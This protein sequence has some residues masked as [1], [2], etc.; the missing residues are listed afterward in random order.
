MVDLPQN[1]HNAFDS[2]DAISLQQ[3]FTQVFIFIHFS[4]S[5]S[6]TTAPAVNKVIQHPTWLIC[7]LNEIRLHLSLRT[8]ITLI[9]HNQHILNNDQNKPGYI[10]NKATGIIYHVHAFKRAEISNFWGVMLNL[11]ASRDSRYGGSHS[12]QSLNHYA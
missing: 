2:M 6:P 10:N 1:G 12:K 3:S 7:V 4:Y 5:L 11:H 8:R 9:L